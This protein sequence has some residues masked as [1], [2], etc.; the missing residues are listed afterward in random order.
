M[1]PSSLPAPVL[2]SKG[3]DDP[4]GDDRGGKGGSD[5]T[6][7]SASASASASSSSSSSSS[8]SGVDDNGSGGNGADDL[9]DT[10]ASSSASASSSSSSSSSGVDDHGSGGNGVDDP[11][12]ASASASA[13][14]SSSSSA[15]T[16]VDDHGSGGNGADDP[17]GASASS[18]AS[19]SSA[20]ASAASASASAS[21]SSSVDDHGTDV[22]GAGKSASFLFDA[23]KYLELNPDFASTVDLGSALAHYLEVGAAQ[24]RAPAGWFDADFYRSAY[25]DLSASGLDDATLFM[26]FNLFGV[27]EGR[28]PGRALAH[29]DG[30]RYLDD[31]P[32]V[33][34]FVNGNLAS[35]MGSAQNGA[36]AHYVIYGAHEHRA[37]FDDSGHVVDSGLFG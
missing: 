32:D 7:S 20:S 5:D 28:T 2:K 36:I 23:A 29:F 11:A 18:S 34:A 16:G 19:A 8:S 27:F 6:S 22:P 35:F 31:N 15:S 14:A 17:A 26:H 12:G 33:A 30:E 24:H 3:A 10:S 9:V 37:A 1:T 13:S 4:P 25:G 21:A